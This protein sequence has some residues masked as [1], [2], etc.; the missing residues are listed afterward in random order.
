MCPTQGST[1]PYPFQFLQE[2]QEGR[3]AEGYIQ[4]KASWNQSKV[5]EAHVWSYNIHLQCRAVP[6]GMQ[7][8][9]IQAGQFWETHA[10]RH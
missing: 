1:F 7:R 10:L 9:L 4:G 3:R 5:G 6:T 8:N 2:A